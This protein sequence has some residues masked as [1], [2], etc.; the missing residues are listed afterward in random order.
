MI[1]L[2]SSE[3]VASSAQSVRINFTTFRELR[4]I[5]HIVIKPATGSL[6]MPLTSILRPLTASLLVWM[7]FLGSYHVKASERSISDDQL[8]YAI[9]RAEGNPNYGILNGSC[10]P[11]EAGMCHYMCKEILKVYRQR[12]SGRGDWIS[13]VAKHWAPIGAKNDPYSLN[14]FWERNVR[15]IVHYYDDAY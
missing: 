14:G 3:M 10:D 1:V 13:Y 15:E 4:G 5:W 7:V 6:H 11:N 9:R 2:S 8:C 12:W